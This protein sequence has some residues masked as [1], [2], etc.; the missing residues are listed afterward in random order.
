MVVYFDT[1]DQICVIKKFNAELE[2]P[3]GHSS[4]KHGRVNA[5]CDDLGLPR[6]AGKQLIGAMCGGIQ[7]GEFNGAA[8]TTEGGRDK[9]Q[10]FF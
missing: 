1:F 8:G 3:A 2:C 7:G 9:L 5:V 6:N 10:S 4:E